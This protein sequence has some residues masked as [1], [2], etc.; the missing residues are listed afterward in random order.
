MEDFLASELFLRATTPDSSVI[1]LQDSDTQ[2]LP[3]F[4]QT[5]QKNVSPSLFPPLTLLKICQ[6]VH[7][8]LSI[9]GWTGSRYFSS[10]VATDVN[11]TAFAQA[12]MKVVSEY[13][14]DGIEFEYAFL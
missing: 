6:N 9:G 11:R 8:I 13:N 3:Q 1:G 10:A 4:V 14:L 12:V 2:L 5:A 7:A